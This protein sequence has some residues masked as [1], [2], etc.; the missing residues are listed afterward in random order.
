M[1]DLVILNDNNVPMTDSLKVAERFG[2]RHGNVIQKIE[3]LECTMEFARLN[4]QLGSYIDGNDQDRKMY[5]LTR[6][7]FSFLVN[8]M[9][10]PKAAEFTEKF[11]SAF[12]AM[13]EGIKGKDDL[14]LKLQDEMKEIQERV[15]LLEGVSTTDTPVKETPLKFPTTFRKALEPLGICSKLFFQYFV[16]IGIMDVNPNGGYIVLR[17]PELFFTKYKYPHLSPQGYDEVVSWL[18]DGKIPCNYIKEVI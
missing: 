12:N 1:N 10:G 2:K 16:N 14:I 8:K 11:I 18:K 13:E 3:A 7:G 6:D 4:F 15:M 9:N 17:R 5:K